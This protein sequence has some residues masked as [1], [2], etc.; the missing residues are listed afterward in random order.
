MFKYCMLGSPQ[1][2]SEAGYPNSEQDGDDWSESLEIVLSVLLA[3]S[4]D[5]PKNQKERT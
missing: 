1:C 2:T 5:V 4:K 3:D